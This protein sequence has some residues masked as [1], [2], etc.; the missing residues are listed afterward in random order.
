MK[1]L[2]KST[3]IRRAAPRLLAVGAALLSAGCVTKLEVNRATGETGAVTGW[4][5]ALPA[6]GFD[7]AISREVLQCR[8]ENGEAKVAIK[9]QVV[10]TPIYV[11]DP[12]QTYAINYEELSSGLKTSSIKV[13]MHDNGMLKQ[14]S[15]EADDR[16]GEVLVAVASGVAKFATGVVLPAAAGGGIPGV[17]SPQRPAAGPPPKARA[18]ECKKQLSASLYKALEQMQAA[19]LAVVAATATLANATDKLNVHIA[20]ASAA[21]D[22]LPAKLQEALITAAESVADARQDLVEAAASLATLKRATTHIETFRWF[23]TSVDKDGML[24]SDPHPIPLPVR[25]RW[26]KTPSDFQSTIDAQMIELRLETTAGRAI[27]PTA[28]PEE[29][30]RYRIPVSGSLMAY[31]GHGGAAVKSRVVDAAIP[32]LG[33]VMSISYKNGLFQSNKIFAAFR[34]DGSLA[35]AEYADLES[36]A[37]NAANTFKQLTDVAAD[38]VKEAQSAPLDALTREKS[39]VDAETNLIRAQTELQKAKLAAEPPGDSVAEKARL[40]ADTS[41]LK[42]KLENLRAREALEMA[43]TTPLSTDAN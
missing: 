24:R 18:S 8:E 26:F 34:P 28:S 10:G 33:H 2:E 17:F 30:V 4:S 38:A 22:K 29:G 27:A 15:S 32:Q 37:E 39:R 42:A 6:V 31:K 7:I 1:N 11:R 12:A 19:K 13:E 21:K 23:Q 16:T 20:N 25:K 43:R 40:E 14:I 9:T 3:M 36:S 35:S 41:L 5:Y